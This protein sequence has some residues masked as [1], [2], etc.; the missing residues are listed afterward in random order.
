MSTK[1]QSIGNGERERESESKAL[2]IVA[3]FISPFQTPNTQ[4]SLNNDRWCS[5]VFSG[6]KDFYNDLNPSTLSGALDIIVVHHEDGSMTCSPFH[7]R[8]GKL[9]ILRSKEKLVYIYAAIANKSTHRCSRAEQT[10][11]VLL[12]LHFLWLTHSIRLAS[13]QHTHSTHNTHRS[14]SKSTANQSTS[15]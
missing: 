7:V 14:K 5:Q 15:R 1:L 12:S 9:Q 3:Q 2:V 13:P 4:H 6:V 8:F 10:S 11:T